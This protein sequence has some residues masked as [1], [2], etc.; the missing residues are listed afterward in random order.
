[1]TPARKLA[2]VVAIQLLILFGVL[3][4]K[5]YTILTGTT[6]L[7]K[8]QPIDPR[9]LLR[10]DYAAVRYEIS[11]ISPTNVVWDGD[12]PRSGDAPVYVELERQQ[13]DYWTAIAVHGDRQ[14]TRD[15]T[16]LIKGRVQ[17]GPGAR[18]IRYGI[19]QVFIP[20]GSGADIPSGTGHTV[21]VEV[22]VDRLGNAVPRHFV[23][24][25]KDI[26]PLLTSSARSPHEIIFGHAGPR[27]TVVRDARW[28][29][30]VLKAGGFKSLKRD[31]KWIDPRAPDGVTILAPYEQAH[32]SQYPGLETGDEAKPMML[33]DLQNDPSE[34]HDVASAHP[35]IVARLKALYDATNKE[36]PQP[37]QQAKGKKKAK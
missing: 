20:E 34:Q 3:G 5:Q 15:G 29:L 7:L 16:V 6:V 2:V 14:H 10:G 12:A 36:V 9:D 35:D 30:H 4:F 23:I 24:D 37:P 28:K 18:Q 26:M 33:F 19:E 25:G 1:M 22:K 27:L 32:P 17:S 21:A 8:V 13:D 31:E 11:I